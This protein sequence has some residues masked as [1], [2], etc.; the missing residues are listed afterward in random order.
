MPSR[1][2]EI[3]TRETAPCGE[4]VDDGDHA[5][6]GKGPARF[7]LSNLR[8]E[9]AGTPACRHLEVPDGAAWLPRMHPI[10]V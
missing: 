10:L 8:P 5:R 4:T 2:V 9:L 3:R 1:V 6:A 7:G